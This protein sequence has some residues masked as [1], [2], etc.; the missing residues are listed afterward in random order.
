MIERDLA[1]YW[2]DRRLLAMTLGWAMV[3]HGMQIIAQKCLACAL[4][5]DIP[6][7]FFLVIVPLIS[8]AATLPFSLQGIGLREASYWYYLSQL[9]VPRE[10]ALALGLLAS[11][12]ALA[13]GLTGL[14][15]F[16]MLR[17]SKA[18]SDPKASPAPVSPQP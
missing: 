1:P 7:T 10:E 11:A 2:H 6:W 16:L 3:V 14:P 17:R 13:L 15:A 18:P 9:G 12:M 4:G 8:M 5:L